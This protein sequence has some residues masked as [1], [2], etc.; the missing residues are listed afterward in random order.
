[1]LKLAEVWF[2]ESSVANSLGMRPLVER[3]AALLERLG[4]EEQSSGTEEVSDHPTGLTHRELE[5]LRLLASGKSNGDIANEL[6]I[7]VHT[8]VYHVT[9]ILAKADVENQTEAAAWAA[10]EGLV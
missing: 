9:N 2:P 3:S 8:V 6:S 10:R 7:S 5:V 4:P 1:M